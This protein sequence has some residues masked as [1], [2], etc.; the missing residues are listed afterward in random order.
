MSEI[1]ATL[2]WWSRRAFDIGFDT[3]HGVDTGAVALGLQGVT[4]PNRDAGIPYDP[5]PWRTVARSLR[6]AGLPTPSGF[7]FVD[8]GCGKGK[9]LL[10]AMTFPFVRIIGIEFS[11]YLCEIAR[12]NV[13][14]ARSLRRRCIHVEIVC[15]DAVAWIPPPDEPLVLFFANPFHFTVMGPVLCNIVESYKHHR[16]PVY[17]IFYRASSSV[18]N[19]NNTLCEASRGSAA[20]LASGKFGAGSVNIYWLPASPAA[21]MTS[22]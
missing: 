1:Q 7:T 22:A 10:E 5:S 21:A 6:M 16:R 18:E 14:S 15:A 4:G 19:I 11:P 8:I 9:V 20:R 12:R 3:L 2:K 13:N 17:M